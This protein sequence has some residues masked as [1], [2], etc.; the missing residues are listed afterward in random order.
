MRFI[1][2]DSFAGLPPPAG[3]DAG[4]AEL[5]AGAWRASLQEALALLRRYGTPLDNIRLVEGWFDRTLTADQAD[6]LDLAR[7]AV[8]HIDSKLH[9]SAE[10]AL[11][12]C[13][14]Y[15]RD[16]T[17]IVFSD[18]LL[19]GGLPHLGS[20]RAFAEWC[21]AHPEWHATVLDR[22][23]LGRIAFVLS[24]RREEPRRRGW[25]RKR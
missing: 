11:A 23:P 6:K 2:F 25:W 13:T 24:R 15:L 17:V 12:F 16:R 3:V 19:F 21:A 8:V 14:P 5:V 18:W 1:G 9:A 10:A 4:R 20:R 7:L 22:H